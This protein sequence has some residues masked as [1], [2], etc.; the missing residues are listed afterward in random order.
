M[1]DVTPLESA[2]RR[3][4]RDKTPSA[5]LSEAVAIPSE[6]TRRRDSSR[7]LTALLVL[8]VV[9]TAAVLARVELPPSGGTDSSRLT[10]PSGE[11]TI[12][13]TEGAVAVDLVSGGRTTELAAVDGGSGRPFVAQLVCSADPGLPGIVLFGFIGASP[14][15]TVAGLPEGRMS[16]GTDGTF[17]Y[18]VDATP[19]PGDVWTITT[20]NATF[21]G[22]IAVWGTPDSTGSVGPPTCVAFDPSTAPSKP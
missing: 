19:S 2:I 12:R 1:Q 11:L 17:L 6:W 22:P 20:P 4:L 15:P 3:E 14:S 13:V 10:I 9:A 8:A 18:A 5:L 21:S 7:R 16:A